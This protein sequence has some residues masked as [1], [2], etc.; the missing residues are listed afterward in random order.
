MG[1]ISWIIL[2]LLAG[3]IAKSIMPGKDPGGCLVTILLG[4]V[5]ASV[6]GW[7]GTQLGWGTVQNFD[8]RGLG[9]SILG[10]LVLLFIYR[11]IAGKR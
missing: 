4:I 9:L 10:S 8:L 6:G 2:G 3:L 11:L 1:I 5:G 7:I